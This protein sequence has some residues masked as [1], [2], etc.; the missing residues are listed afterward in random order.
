MKVLLVEDDQYKQELIEN[1][2]TP[3]CKDVAIDV[4]RSVSQAVDLVRASS[5]DF[6]ILDMA[7]PSHETKLGGAQPISQPSGGLEVLMELDYEGRSDRVVVV[8]QFPEV[9]IDGKLYPL[10]KAKSVIM[11]HVYSYIIGA[12]HFD[13]RGSAWADKLLQVM[14]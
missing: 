13:A 5:F 14:E 7:L 6:I 9:E 10:S 11:E 3:A 12:I 2:I 1:A 4:A 8:T